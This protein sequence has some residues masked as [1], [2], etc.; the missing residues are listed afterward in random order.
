M[1]ADPELVLSE[2]PPQAA[3]DSRSGRILAGLSACIRQFDDA[4]TAAEAAA[5]ALR[6]AYEAALPT[7][8]PRGHTRALELYRYVIERPRE[9][10]RLRLEWELFLPEQFRLD[11]FGG[12]INAGA[13]QILISADTDGMAA[14]GTA[15]YNQ[16][17]YSLITTNNGETANNPSDAP[18]RSNTRLNAAEDRVKSKRL[19]PITVTPCRSSNST[20]EPTTSNN[21]GNT[22]TRTPTAFNV[23]G[24]TI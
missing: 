3:I 11:N 22:L 7:D 10:K 5:E 4:A 6:P 15:S 1:L 24:R 13:N 2:L 18:N 23:R 19:T 12:D 20:E 9:P 8:L 21:R 17:G 14:A 16:A